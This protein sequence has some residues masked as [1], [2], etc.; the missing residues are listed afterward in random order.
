MHTYKVARTAS[1]ILIALTLL[2]TVLCVFIVWFFLSFLP[3]GWKWLITVLLI[4]ISIGVI[5]WIPAWQR[6]LS[7]TITSTKITR[8]GGIFWQHESMMQLSALQWSTALYTPFGR[9]TGL[10][11]IPLH[12]YGGSLYLSFLRRVDAEEIQSIIQHAVWGESS[13][14]TPNTDKIPPQNDNVSVMN[15]D[16]EEAV[17]S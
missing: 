2:L 17:E 7:Y 11:F 15:T 8:K 6:S 1:I 9:Y 16:D 12:A 5:I 13:D 3:H 10:N 14:T 4:L